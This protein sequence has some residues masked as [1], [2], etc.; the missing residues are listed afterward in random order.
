MFFSSLSSHFNPPR[1]EEGGGL[2]NIAAYHSPLQHG[3]WRQCVIP[4]YHKL[5]HALL[6]SHRGITRQ[7]SSSEYISQLLTK[8]ESKPLQEISVAPNINAFSVENVNACCVNLTGV[9]V[10]DSSLNRYHICTKFPPFVAILSML[11]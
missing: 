9:G 7:W 3:W 11:I 2:V 1:R 8:N 5:L 6:D 10:G 4:S